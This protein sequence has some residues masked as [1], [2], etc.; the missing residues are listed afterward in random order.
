M[1]KGQHVQHYGTSERTETID[2]ID[3]WTEGS[4]DGRMDGSMNE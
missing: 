2:T 4:M 1:M 3:G